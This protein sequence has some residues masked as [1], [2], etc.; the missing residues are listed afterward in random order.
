MAPH[1]RIL[2]VLDDY[3]G[4]IYSGDVQRLRSAFHPSAVL[5]GEVEGQPYHKLLEDY[6][7]VVRGRTSPQ[8]LGEVF[9]MEPI[10]IEVQGN[11]ALAK[12]R[13]PMLGFEYVD[14][15]SLLREDGR[16][17]IAAKLFTHLE[18][19]TP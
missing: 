3:F 15:L 18:R 9:A 1:H 7:D 4:G 11:I 19:S 14:F 17:A 16:W 8:A 13:C 2:R 10:A 12:V 5:W 6:L